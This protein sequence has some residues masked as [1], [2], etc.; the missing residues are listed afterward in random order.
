MNRRFDIRLTEAARA[1]AAELEKEGRALRFSVSRSGCCSMAVS[2]YPDAE[3]VNDQVL[4]FDG[5][6]ILTRDEY[7]EMHWSGIID[8]K[9]R[10]LHKGFSW[11]AR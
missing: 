11:K 5:I 3:R 6:R 2:I 10:G 4:E 9:P 1:A 8:Y 7:P